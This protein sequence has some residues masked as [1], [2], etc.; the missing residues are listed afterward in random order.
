M[1]K[2]NLHNKMVIVTGASSGIGY[3][4]SKYLI[5]NF[6]VTVIG[7]ARN[8]ANLNRV[9]REFNGKFIP[10]AVNV[11]QKSSW[12]K[13]TAFLS[14]NHYDIYGIV[15]SAGV[16]PEFLP[17][18][19]SSSESLV[20]IFQ[21]NF[22][23]MVYSAEYILPLIR[24]NSGF[25]VNISSSSALCPFIG[26]TSYTASKSAVER[27][28]EALSY[29]EKS[30]NVVTV[31]PGFTKS[32]IMRSQ[33]AEDKDIA[34]I[35]KISKSPKKV[36]KKIIKKAVNGRR[37]IIVGLDAHMM[38]FLYKFFPS[39]APKI[40]GAVLKKSKLKIFKNI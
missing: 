23:S 11:A 8:V 22:Y 1:K 30:V 38:N 4:I 36:A 9:S 12:E 35:N 3:E 34:L 25:M 10:F 15:N 5:E 33:N 39:L 26:V 40:I 29:E 14:K 31:M 24:K 2:L 16:L 20:K 27:F 32:N 17:F 18:S 28:S 37:R 6:S 7:I 19:K 13:I 21:I